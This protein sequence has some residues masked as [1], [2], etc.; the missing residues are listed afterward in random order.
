MPGN[1]WQPCSCTRGLSSSTQITPSYPRS[2]VP[3]RHPRNDGTV[4]KWRK[5]S[6]SV[7][8]E[9]F[10]Q[11]DIP[12]VHVGNGQHTWRKPERSPYLPDKYGLY[13][14]R[15][16]SSDLFFL[17]T[18]RFLLPYDRCISVRMEAGNHTVITAEPILLDSSHIPKSPRFVH[19]NRWRI[20]HMTACRF[21]YVAQI[22]FM[23]STYFTAL[24]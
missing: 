1:P 3:C 11:V 20:A 5:R 19:G 8:D 13:Q 6:I 16:T 15:L 2:S 24:A 10:H 7:R 23:K 12:E 18:D 17:E 21:K 14:G 22:F 9:L 4:P